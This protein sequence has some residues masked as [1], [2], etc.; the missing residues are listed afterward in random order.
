M[1]VNV[2]QA[3]ADLVL[4]IITAGATVVIALVALFGRDFTRLLMRPRL[5]VSVDNHKGVR[6]FLSTLEGHRVADVRWFHVNAETSCRAFSFNNARVDLIAV[7]EIG[8]D[9]K[10]RQIWRGHWR[11][12]WRHEP[13]VREVMPGLFVSYPFQAKTIGPVAQADLFSIH[14]TEGFLI[15][16]LIPNELGAYLAEVKSKG[17]AMRLAL[18]VRAVS[19][20][21]DSKARRIEIS[22]SGKWASADSDF[23]LQ[24]SE[25]DVSQEEATR[26]K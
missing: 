2:T 25:S 18:I 5:L 13:P 14:E 7:E 6:A 10:W 23:D 22:W 15:Q 19:D 20:E 12:Q 21:Q 26:G 11:L 1:I 9:T 8:P 16:Q 4:G 24:L 3:S 17:G